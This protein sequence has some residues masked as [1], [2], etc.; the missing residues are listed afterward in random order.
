MYK[1]L[2]GCK[3][4]LIR[5]NKSMAERLEKHGEKGGQTKEIKVWEIDWRNMEVRV[6]KNE[7]RLKMN[8]GEEC[9]N[10]KAEKRGNA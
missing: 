1:V 2:L 6:E 8:F 7:E 3:I 9:T 4:K 10:E 5:V